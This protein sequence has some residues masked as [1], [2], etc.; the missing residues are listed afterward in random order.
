MFRSKSSDKS[1]DARACYTAGTNINKCCY[2]DLKS[3]SGVF[4]VSLSQCIDDDDRLSS[5]RTE[6]DLRKDSLDLATPLAIRT[7]PSGSVSSTSSAKDSGCSVSPASPSSLQ[8]SD[9]DYE[10]TKI[11]SVSLEALSG[12]TQSGKNTSATA[13]NRCK[14]LRCY[15]EKVPYI[16]K[17]C[18]EHLE[19]NALQT[20]GLFRVGVS[21]KR[22][23]EVSIEQV[24]LS[25]SLN[26]DS[27][28]NAHD[29]AGLI[30]EF[31]REL[32]EPLMTKELC[33]SFLAI[34]SKMNVKDQSKIL[35]YLIALLPSS[36]RDTLYTLLKFL[37]IVS[38]NAHDRQYNGKFI[39][40]NKM[41]SQNL[42]I[43]FAPT[44]LLDG[45]SVTK[46]MSV[47]YMEQA[48]D[49][50]QMMID[51][52]KDLFIISRDLHNE[53]L[54]TLCEMNSEQLV[55]ALAFKVKNVCG[56]ITIQLDENDERE[57]SSLDLLPLF[58]DSPNVGIFSSI[59]PTRAQ[60]PSLR[61]NLRRNSDFP[62]STIHTSRSSEFL[63]VPSSS[64]AQRLSQ[65]NTNKTTTVN[66]QTRL[67]TVRDI[68]EA[69]MDQIIFRLIE[70]PTEQR[71]PTEPIISVTSFDDVNDTT[72]PL[73]SITMYDQNRRLIIRPNSLNING[74]E[75][76][77]I[78]QSSTSASSPSSES[79]QNTNNNTLSLREIKPYAR[80]KTAPLSPGHYLSPRTQR[81]SAT[82]AK[83]L[84]GSSTDESP[85]PLSATKQ[86]ELTITLV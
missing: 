81:E 23:T 22:L 57:L 66:T 37:H 43:V 15:P 61:Y 7:S 30:K 46:D 67:P 33:S 68:R 2:L 85:S 56:I 40:G 3:N 86:S 75:T 1:K 52:Y 14:T 83:N 27:T 41:D 25:R 31:L 34:R 9:S 10:N 5:G 63:Q 50:L 49:V 21:K 8:V 38:L 60:P 80:S 26:F 76:L 55:R 79:Q 74:K 42:A 51:Q 18:C 54:N 12:Q 35:G 13:L 48:K 71:H 59:I 4:G 20:I 29:V 47:A 78:A 82:S 28:T 32:P 84:C 53:L 45:K 72:T 17:N 24:N 70:P 19:R 36:N 58:Y 77:A 65:L 11:R 69:S 64:S 73:T 62:Y 6:D 39:P 44:I 16:I